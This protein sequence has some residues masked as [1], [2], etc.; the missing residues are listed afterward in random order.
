MAVSRQN[1]WVVVAIFLPTVGSLIFLICPMQQV[2]IFPDSLTSDYCIA[3]E[4]GKQWQ[5]KA[6]QKGKAHLGV[7]VCVCV[8]VVS[9][10]LCLLWV[11][12]LAVTKNPLCCFISCQAAHVRFQRCRDI[13]QFFSSVPRGLLSSLNESVQFSSVSQSCPTLCDPMNLSTPGLPTYNL[14]VCK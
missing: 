8:C 6:R 12:S 5:K 2:P 9:V 14:K 1:G 11:A 7:C 4:N 3:P 13:L 10:F